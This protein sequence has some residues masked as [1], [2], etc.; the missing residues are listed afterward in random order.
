MKKSLVK[1]KIVWGASEAEEDI[2]HEVPATGL[3]SKR[4][5][6]I[7]IMHSNAVEL[8]KESNG[9][10]STSNKHHGDNGDNSVPSDPIS[11]GKG[12]AKPDV[13]DESRPEEYTL[14]SIVVS[15][16]IHWPS[17]ILTNDELCMKMP[18]IDIDNMWPGFIDENPLNLAT[19]M[20]PSPRQKHSIMLAEFDKKFNKTEKDHNTRLLHSQKMAGSHKARTLD[21][22]FHRELNEQQVQ[23]ANSNQVLSRFIHHQRQRRPEFI[24]ASKPGEIMGE[25]TPVT[26]AMPT[27]VETSQSSL[28]TFINTGDRS[29]AFEAGPDVEG[30]RITKGENLKSA[31]NP[32][33]KQN[34]VLNLSVLAQVPRQRVI[35]VPQLWLW[36]IDSKCMI[37]ISKFLML[38]KCE[39]HSTISHPHVHSLYNRYEAD[40]RA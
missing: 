18:F 7:G 9:D 15:L 4:S 10:Y 29:L 8:T 19:N 16:C 25:A 6:I 28:G 39:W 11:P 40:H 31:A 38:P 32:D 21:H 37:T 23:D 26:L 24:A 30:Q 36:K 14:A 13:A 5:S 1:K 22:Y 34:T 33:S 2:R 17:S 27:A 20:E 35:V 12:N 3:Q